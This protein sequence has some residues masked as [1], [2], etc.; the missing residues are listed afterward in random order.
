[1]SDH[2]HDELTLALLPH[3]LDGT[4]A[5]H[6]V[7]EFLRDPNA[8]GAADRLLESIRKTFEDCIPIDVAVAVSLRYFDE[9]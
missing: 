4:E 8:P 5:H 7:R 6:C 3:V 2:T 9:S 1:M